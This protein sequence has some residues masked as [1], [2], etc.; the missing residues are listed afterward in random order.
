M[1]AL[2]SRRVY[3]KQVF[4]DADIKFDVS[5]MFD[6]FRQV[7]KGAFSNELLRS[8][9]KLWIHHVIDACW[10]DPITREPWVQERGG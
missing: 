5:I 1:N 8:I 7:S 9:P 4:G 10:P 2:Q 6:S 3:A